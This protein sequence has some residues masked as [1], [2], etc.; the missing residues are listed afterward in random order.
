MAAKKPPP[1]PPDTALD[2]EVPPAGVPPE[3]EER[4]NA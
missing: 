3:A 1:F 2:G 4:I